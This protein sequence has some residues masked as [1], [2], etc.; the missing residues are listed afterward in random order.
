MPRRATLRTAAV[1]GLLKQVSYAS[2]SAL[3][4]QMIAAERELRQIDFSRDYPE[5]FIAF[6]VTGF[7]PRGSSP[8]LVSG[9][10]VR[11]DLG[12]FILH[13]SERLQLRPNE[14]PGGATTLQELA[15]QWGVTPRSLRRWRALGLVQHWMSFAHGQRTIGVFRECAA[16]FLAQHGSR[17]ARAKVMRRLSPAERQSIEAALRRR[18]SGGA[19]PTRAAA[20]VALEAH[21]ARETVRGLLLRSSLVKRRTILRGH[22][23]LLAWRAWHLGMSLRTIAAQMKLPRARVVRAVV[24]QRTLRLAGCAEGVAAS[25]IFSR[26]DAAEVLLAPRAVTEQLPLVPREAAELLNASPGGGRD[27]PASG[28]RN[29][30]GPEADVLVQRLAAYRFLRRRAQGVA[31]DRRSAAALDRAETDLRWSSRLRC[32]MLLGAVGQAAARLPL[33]RGREWQ[34]DEVV[35]RERA[36]A[37]A[38]RVASEMLERV[39]LELAATRPVELGRVTVLELDRRLAAGVKLGVRGLV[40]PN[41][42]TDVPNFDHL[43]SGVGELPAPDARLLAERFGWV[44]RPHTLHELASAGSTTSAVVAARIERAMEQVAASRRR[45]KRP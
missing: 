6:R 12:A 2:E 5:D 30:R 8:T 42:A 19:S 22:D 45:A 39:D 40:H 23:A 14:R 17:V 26:S 16:A 35:E 36:L 9:A 38:W 1:G 3:T 34:E 27:A 25:P 31:T 20:D 10:A 15:R 33:L 32:A 21:R 43:R 18:L 7:R 13:L 44:G 29:R 37:L 41:W 11:T 4:R 24:R 28:P